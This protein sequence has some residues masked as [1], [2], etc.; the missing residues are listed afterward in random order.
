MRKKK[1]DLRA[2]ALDPE[3]RA[4]AEAAAE[5]SGLTLK[6]WLEQAIRTSARG[7]PARAPGSTDSPPSTA[8]S[9]DRTQA[10]PEAPPQIAGASPEPSGPAEPTGAP[11][12]RGAERPADRD[13]TDEEILAALDALSQQVDATERHMDQ[14]VTPLG[15][16]IKTLEE[17][18][19]NLKKPA[20]I[21][22]PIRW[23]VAAAVLLAGLAS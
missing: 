2:Q 13:V 18:L 4:A 15:K 6:E 22:I 11:P 21:V 19:A 12:A 9:R 5:D 10:A 23:L 8:E 14:A 1:P 3:T 20:P 17:Q 16:A 7:A